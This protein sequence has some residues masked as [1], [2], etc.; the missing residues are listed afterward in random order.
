MGRVVRGTYVS[1]L[2]FTGIYLVVSSGAEFWFG[3][4]LG[5]FACG[6]ASRKLAVYHHGG[7]LEVAVLQKRQ[8]GGL[9]FFTRK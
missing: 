7:Y 9:M 6:A 1:F 5:I 8:A 3:T 2:V 4:A